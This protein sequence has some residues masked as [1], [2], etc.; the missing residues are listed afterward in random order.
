MERTVEQE[1]QLIRDEVFRPFAKYVN[2][3][4]FE[5]EEKFEKKLKAFVEKLE[6]THRWELSH[7]CKLNPHKVEAAIYVKMDDG[8]FF[9]T[10]VV[11]VP[12]ENTKG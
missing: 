8:E 7:N 6:E 10:E 5:D 1:K 3:L 9:S 4:L 11:V 12:S 2:T